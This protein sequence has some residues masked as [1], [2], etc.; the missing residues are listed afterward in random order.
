MKQYVCI[1]LSLINNNFVVIWDMVVQN[2]P[3]GIE[4]KTQ[5]FC[6]VN[7]RNSNLT[8]T[9]CGFFYCYFFFGG[10]GLKSCHNNNN[11]IN[12]EIS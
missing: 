1:C 10:G 8:R 6:M 7:Y 4:S 11:N 9:S 3:L 2:N 5:L 12:K